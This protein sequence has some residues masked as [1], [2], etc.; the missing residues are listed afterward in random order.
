MSI[1]SHTHDVPYVGYIIPIKNQ[2]ALLVRYTPKNT[3]I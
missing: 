2:N 1:H 3:L